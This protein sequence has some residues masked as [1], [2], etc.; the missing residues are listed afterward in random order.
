MQIAQTP[1]RVRVRAL[2]RPR[3]WDAPDPCV[4]A[5]MR[6][7]AAAVALQRAGGLGEAALPS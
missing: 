5:T 7:S 4:R 3:A 1:A 6:A 2:I